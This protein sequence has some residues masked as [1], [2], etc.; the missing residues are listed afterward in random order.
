MNLYRLSLFLIISTLTCTVN[1]DTVQWAKGFTAD[2][3][4][5]IEREDG[6]ALTAAEISHIVYQIIPASGGT[7]MYEAI[8]QGGCKPTFVDT[9]SFVPTGP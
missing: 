6:T 2:C 4:N 3:E 8:M 9:K 1:A 5:P 7:P